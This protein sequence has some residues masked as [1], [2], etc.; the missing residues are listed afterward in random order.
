[1]SLKP[2]EE[3]SQGQNDKR[4]GTLSLG[5][6]S[7]PLTETEGFQSLSL[8]P[9]IIKDRES[10]SFNILLP[11]AGAVLLRSL[12]WGD[13]HTSITWKPELRP[14]RRRLS[15]P[16]SV[17][18]ETCLCVPMVPVYVSLPSLHWWELQHAGPT[19]GGGEE[20]STRP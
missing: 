10:C 5:K 6:Q 14:E 16:Q 20:H 15:E 13:A 12:S 3:C 18:M 9:T 11:V 7:S 2:G 4:T 8:S 1:M 17:R 19:A